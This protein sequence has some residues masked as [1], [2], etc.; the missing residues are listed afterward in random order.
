M[1]SN[2]IKSRH[3][4]A[5]DSPEHNQVVALKEDFYSIGR[6]S[7]NKIVINSQE[8]S[9]K[10]VT[11]TKKID[12]KTNSSYFILTDGDEKG[13]RSTN[14]ILVN[15]SKCSEKILNHGDIIFFSNNIKATYYIINSNTMPPSD[16]NSSSFSEHRHTLIDYR[17]TQSIELP[18]LEISTAQ[19]E[20][21]ASLVELSPNPILE[22]N[23]E[24]K[25]TY[26]N[27]AARL[28]FPDLIALDQKHPLLL[29]LLP[30]TQHPKGNLLIREFQTD[31][32]VFEQHIHY[33]PDH[34]SIRIYL[35]DITQRKRAEEILHYQAFHD[36]L[37]GLCNRT[38]F[39]EHLSIALANARRAQYSMAVL[40]LDLDGFKMIN[41]VLGHGAGDQSLQYFAQRLRAQLRMG[42][43]LS[44][45]GG[46]EFTIL[47][48]HLKQADEPATIAQRI[49]DSLVQPFRLN[50]Q[51]IYLKSSIGIAV[52]PQ[53]GED[54]ETLIKNADSA[55][56]RTK[57][58]GRNHYQFYNSHMTSQSTERF[59]L[60]T[61]LHQAIDRG[62]LHLHYQPQI[63]IKT[64][65]IQG[66]E[67]L[68]RWQHPQ[69]GLIS[70]TKFIPI[71]EETGLILAIDEWV[72]R[73][74]CQQN[75]AWQKA[76]LP[77]V[78]VAVNLSARQFQ[79]P[80]LAPLIEQVLQDTQLDSYFLEVE[81]TETA[82]IKNIDL[83][84][85]N[86]DRLRQLGVQVAMDDFGTGYSSLS[87]LKE[88]LFHT[89]K[90]DSAFV[91]DITKFSKE[92]TIISAIMTLSEGFNLR[93]VV[94]GV[95][96]AHQM[97]IL[98]DLRC[99]EMQG[100]LFSRPLTVQ[101][102][103]YF[104]SQSNHNILFNRKIA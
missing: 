75:K 23:W 32:T 104:L 91:K 21:L 83:T 31:Q 96:T 12:K 58:Q 39:H 30:H 27:T 35:F 100:Y 5:I 52:Y 19:D 81:V 15:G 51:E 92:T 99:E 47:L 50:Q 17:Q 62:E 85:H 26:Q 87:Y 24:G 66:M 45:W 57:E 16:K 20:Q 4:L 98:E 77:P 43:V 8:I 63:N 89:L 10:H 7:Q 2:T 11:I 70:P 86:L 18:Q 6:H 42:D 61:L 102:S 1:L 44:R 93:V 29:Q 59:Q 73:T 22:L 95:E 34:Q 25:I 33:L 14:G 97:K 67:A 101:D 82:L 74:A 53:D 9:R 94:E 41:D 80:H 79:N 76:G 36:Q 65:E 68:I 48:P 40:F 49:L 46:D 54:A 55:L 71:A 90:I 78:K 84:R 103:T 56:Y 60:E 88:L 13:N 69:Q 64:G 37:T 72:L 38:L 28:Q 3:I